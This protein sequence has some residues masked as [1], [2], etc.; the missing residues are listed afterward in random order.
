[1]TQRFERF[2]PEV[3]ESLAAISERVLT[4]TELQ[5]YLDA[6][7]AEGEREDLEAFIIW[8]QRKYST[9]LERLRWARRSY[10]Q[11]TRNVAERER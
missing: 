3:A 9:P 10:Q 5:R 6:P 7:F 4:S 1:M 8:F 2:S 11:W